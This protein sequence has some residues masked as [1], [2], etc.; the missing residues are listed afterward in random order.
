MMMLFK[1]ASG[2]SANKQMIERGWITNEYTSP[3]GNRDFAIALH[4]IYH[5]G[6]EG[7]HG[8]KIAAIEALYPSY[9]SQSIIKFFFDHNLGFRIINL[10][11]FVNFLK[12]MKHIGGLP[13]EVSMERIIKFKFNNGQVYKWDKYKFREYLI[14]GIEKFGFYQNDVFEYR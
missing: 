4:H 11:D 2:D 8:N 6:K 10:R 3:R 14:K 13:K 12:R 1:L 5:S 9:T 7:E